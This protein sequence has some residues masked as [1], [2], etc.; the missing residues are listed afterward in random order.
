MELKNIAILGPRGN[1]GSALIAELLKDGPRFNITAVTRPTSPY[2][3]PPQTSITHKTVD[4]AS[5]DSLT[6]AFT[7]QDAVVNCITGGATQYEPTRL[8]I[9]AAV[10][11]GVKLYFANEFVGHVTSEQYRRM[12][13]QAV[14]AKVRI[15]GELEVLGR[16]GGMKWTSLNG[17][18]FFDMWLMKGPAGIDIRNKRA[19]IYGT[20]LNP[21][22]WT[23]LPTIALAAANMLRNPDAIA[24]RPIYINTVPNLTQS[25]LLSAVESVLGA[26]FAVDY[27]DIAKINANAR[28]AVERGEVAKGM[29]GLAIS[30]Q[31]Y[32]GDCGNDFRALVENERV[33]VEVQSVE[34]AVA[35]AV[36]DWGVEN[37]VVESFFG[38]EACEV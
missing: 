14:G 22:C 23:P 1:V 20:G 16:E 2:T 29:K 6:A 17:G 32:E 35:R 9:D 7:G 24:N 18:P 8:V 15:R 33:G 34:D 12:P 27:I 30:N 26:K 31:F 21:L 11:A 19:R 36:A 38:I 28:I 3:P 13:E 25:G 4:Y 10:A 37:E 5:L